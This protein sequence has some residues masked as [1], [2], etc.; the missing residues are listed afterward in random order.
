MFVFLALADIEHNKGFPDIGVVTP[1]FDLGVIIFLVGV[2]NRWGRGP[3][4]P[5][6]GFTTRN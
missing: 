5:R 4:G 3:H 6:R 2:P 1:W